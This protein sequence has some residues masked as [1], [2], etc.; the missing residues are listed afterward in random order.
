MILKKFF[1]VVIPVAITAAFMISCKQES[2][3]ERAAR[4]H[5]RILTIDS[6]TDTPLVLGRDEF[7]MGKRNDPS[8]GGGKL[9]FP[10]M[11]EG[12]LDA[13]FFA[14]FLSQGPLNEE[15]YNHAHDRALKIFENISNEMEANRDVADLAL[16]PDDASRLKKEGKRAVYLG[17]ENAYP[18]GENLELAQQYWDL[19]ARYITLCHTRNNQFSDSSNDTPQHGGL[20][21][22]GK[23]LVRK[24]NSMGM[25]IDVSHISDDAFYQVVELSTLPVI[26]SHSNTRAI[27]DDP[28]NLSDDMLLELAKNGGVVQ[29]CFLYVK[30][31]PPNVPR[32]SARVVL[33]EK[34]NHFQNLSEEQ[35]KSAR[36]EWQEINRQFPSQMATVSDLVDHMDHI[37][38][39]IGI[40]HVGIGTDFDGGGELEDC[41]D[42]SELKN[43]TVEMLRRNYSEKDIEKVWSGN[44]MRV[45]RTN[46][47]ARNQ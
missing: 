8:N 31:F 6:H 21:E 26:A 37:V 44:F 28:R 30:N 10:R 22:L 47:A 29:L 7:S 1:L 11:Q 43:I 38:N 41:Y 2:H 45:F 46:M 24:M 35:M 15:A 27:A 5:K 9:D 34:Y 25:M 40:D 33:R 18:M 14:V 12:G 20:S 19:G 42:V 36:E 23:D 3:H 39:L 17:V 32:D 4:I 16:T 13:A